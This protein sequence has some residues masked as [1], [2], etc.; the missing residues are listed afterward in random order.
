MG[1]RGKGKI[2]LVVGEG[3]IVVPLPGGHNAAYSCNHGEHTNWRCCL[4]RA[5]NSKLAVSEMASVDPK[6]FLD[7]VAK[8]K[9]RRRH[10]PG[11]IAGP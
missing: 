10:Q 4:R 1:R 3:D 5:R 11:T 2:A 7:E 8:L 6:A 9:G